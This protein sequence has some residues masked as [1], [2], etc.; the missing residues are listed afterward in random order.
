[1]YKNILKLLIGNNIY[2]YCKYSTMLIFMFNL[3]VYYSILKD[4]KLPLDD[5]FFILLELSISMYMLIAIIY[6]FVIITNYRNYKIEQYLAKDR[7]DSYVQRIMASSLNH[8]LNL[9]IAL[10]VANVKKIYKIVESTKC[11]L[12]NTVKEYW[13]TCANRKQLGVTESF[14]EAYDE[15]TLALERIAAPVKVM[16]NIKY[17]KA[18]NGSQ[19]IIALIKNAYS[20]IRFVVPG[21]RLSLEIED[22]DNIGCMLAVG[23][24][25]DNGSI[26]NIFS[27]LIKNAAE[28]S[29][30]RIIFKLSMYNTL[31]RRCINIKVIDNGSGIDK[32]LIDTLFQYGETT[33]EETLTNI[34]T[35]DRLI[36]KV[37][38]LFVSNIS[39]FN[40]H[41]NNN[42]LRGSGLYI[43]KEV[44]T[45]AGGSIDLESP[46]G[47]PGT[48][49]TFNLV[50]PVKDRIQ[51]S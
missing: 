18:G 32:N 31:L 41:N 2:N 4:T 9:P 14:Q 11:D 25:L 28:A 24:G 44:L 49:T 27:N 5:I 1:M 22:N 45:G 40:P 10:A 35:L 38:K 12:D 7:L 37:L 39:V 42:T 36:E 48:F 21:T 13:A 26:I 34:S 20:G 50:F 19:S 6:I 29:A 16:E 17:V 8:E 30:T 33:K 47:K 15:L 43:A 46:G 3:I 23:Y 51:H